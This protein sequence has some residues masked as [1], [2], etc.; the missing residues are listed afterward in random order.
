MF[1]HQ[2]QVETHVGS[3][4]PC[5]Q[6]PFS[7]FTLIKQSFLTPAYAAHTAGIHNGSHTVLCADLQ[8]QPVLGSTLKGK[9]NFKQLIHGF[10]EVIHWHWRCTSVDMLMGSHC[11]FV[12]GT[13]EAAVCFDRFS[14]QILL[15]VSCAELEDEG[16]HQPHRR[17]RW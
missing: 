8:Y 15:C 14:D 13:L 4:S 16:A 11:R 9:D 17:L 1:R 10:A 3:I 12:R 6:C 5:W 7:V 2:Q